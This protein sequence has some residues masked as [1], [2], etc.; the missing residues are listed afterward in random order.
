MTDES[1]VEP[2]R[3]GRRPTV[4]MLPMDDAPQDGKAVWLYDHDNTREQATWKNT[5][6]FDA[7][8]RLWEPVGFWVKRNTGGIKIEFEPL[9]WMPVRGWG[10]EL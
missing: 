5:R 10:D 9:G 6:R 3:R 2:K 4:E 1:T 7:Q 8:K